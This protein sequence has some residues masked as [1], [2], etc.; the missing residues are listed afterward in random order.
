MALNSYHAY[1]STYILLECFDKI[2]CKRIRHFVNFVKEDID[3]VILD[4]QL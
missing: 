3:E 2:E 4:L 1:E